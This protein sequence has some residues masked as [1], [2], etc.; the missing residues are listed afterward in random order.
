[1]L[2]N[3]D[4]D[5]DGNCVF[6]GEKVTGFKNQVATNHWHMRPIPCGERAIND[7][8]E[9]K[10]TLEAVMQ[11]ITFEQ[12]M[13]IFK[14][15]YLVVGKQTRTPEEM[16]YM[17][18]DYYADLKTYPT[19]LIEEACELYRKLPDDNQFMPTSGRL[20]ALMGAK[21]AKMNFLKSRIEKILGV[22]MAPTQKQNRTLSLDEALDKLTNNIG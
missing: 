12:M 17:F 5:W 2:N 4:I 11:P 3:K 1:M 8:K 15:L 20:I 16:K 14:K 19:K 13:V 7:A 18:N 6:E 10:K 22:Y 9:A 21:W